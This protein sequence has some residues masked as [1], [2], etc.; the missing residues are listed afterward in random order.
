MGATVAGVMFLI[1]LLGV[2]LYYFG[3]ARR[4]QAVEL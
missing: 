1:I 2:L 4:V 3:F